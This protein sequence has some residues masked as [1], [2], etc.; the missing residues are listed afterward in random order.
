MGINIPI[1]IL[2]FAVM[3]LLLASLAVTRHG[4]FSRASKLHRKCTGGIFWSFWLR[5]FFQ[6]CLE[7]TISSGIYILVR[8]KLIAQSGGSYTT[9]FF[10]ND[11]F[12]FCTVAVFCILP[13]FILV[14]YCIQFKKFGDKDF[15]TRYGSVYDGMKTNK[16]SVIFFPIFF[17]L[18]R[19]A[20]TCMAFSLQEYPTCFIFILTGLTL[21]EVVYLMQFRPFESKLL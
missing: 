13:L 3:I 16:R 19:I 4:R 12:S 18:R 21:V 5:L 20:F 8:P 6:G 17:V 7:L 11:F 10:F 14:F 2:T 9:F 15:K 1:I